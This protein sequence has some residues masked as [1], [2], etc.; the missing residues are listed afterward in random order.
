MRPLTDRNIESELS[1][2]YLHAIA[3]HS[4]MTCTSS[5]RHEDNNGIDAS[6]TAWGPFPQENLLQEVDLNIQLKA[7]VSPLTEVRETWS[8][9]FS[10]VQQYDDLRAEN[11]ATPRFLV[12]LFLAATKNNWLTCSAEE[13]TLRQ[14]AYWVS[15]RGAP[16]VT[17]SSGTTVYLPRAQLFNPPGLSALALR[18]SNRDIPRYEAP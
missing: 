16:A 5:N 9:F 12:V 10:G 7:T 1:Y 18:L 15:L 14:C 2:A 13:L 4:G 3:S 8:Y 17:N 6:L 11:I